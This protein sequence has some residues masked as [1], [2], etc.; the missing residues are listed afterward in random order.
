MDEDVQQSLAF[1]LKVFHETSTLIFIVVGVWLEANKL[2]LYNGDLTGRISTINA[3][4]WEANDLRKVIEAG[5]TLLKIKIPDAVKDGIVSG[6]Q[7]NVGLLQEVCYRLCEKYG[8]W[9]SQTQITEV[10][11][12]PD[13]GDS[14]R[15]RR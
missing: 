9:K 11:A 5:E 7:S 10:G 2:T 14:S 15:C 8:I 1:D 13:A 4:E 3:D 12:V 6:C